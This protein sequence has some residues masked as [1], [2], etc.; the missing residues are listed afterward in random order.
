VHK[1]VRNQLRQAHSTAK[2]PGDFGWLSLSLFCLAREPESSSGRVILSCNG[3][4]PQCGLCGYGIASR[5]D[6]RF[7]GESEWMIHLQ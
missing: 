5:K 7:Q 3:R 4:N 2:L 1:E 6:A